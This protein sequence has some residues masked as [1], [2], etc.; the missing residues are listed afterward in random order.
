[1]IY[2]IVVLY[3]GKIKTRGFGA[4]AMWAWITAV[5]EHGF[6]ISFVRAEV[7]VFHKVADWCIPVPFSCNFISV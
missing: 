1:M 3:G 2:E 4:L 6:D 5:S 7:A